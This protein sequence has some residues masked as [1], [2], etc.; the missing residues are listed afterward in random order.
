MNRSDNGSGRI[1]PHAPVRVVNNGPRTCGD[2]RTLI[3]D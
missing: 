2:M 1:G 3:A